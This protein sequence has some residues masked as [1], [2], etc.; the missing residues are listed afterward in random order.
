[1]DDKPKRRRTR[2]HAVIFYGSLAVAAILIAAKAA[3]IDNPL[4]L[5][6]DPAERNFIRQFHRNR[7]HRIVGWFPALFRDEVIHATRKPATPPS[8]HAR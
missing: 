2:W 6:N 1:V 8:L 7:G 4:A 3:G 5:L